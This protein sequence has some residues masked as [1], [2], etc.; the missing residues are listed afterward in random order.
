M[1]MAKIFEDECNATIN[2]IRKHR[3]FADSFTELSL[4]DV[5]TVLKQTRLFNDESTISYG[6]MLLR[7]EMYEALEQHLLGNF[8]KS[9]EELDHCIAVC[10]RMKVMNQ[11]AADAQKWSNAEPSLSDLQTIYEEHYFGV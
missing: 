8:E 7:E 11:I 9:N 6:S 1:S 10:R 3:K 4:D 2:A 5:Q